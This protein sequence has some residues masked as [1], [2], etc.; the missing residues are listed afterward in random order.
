MISRVSLLSSLVLASKA[1]RA[2]SLGLSPAVTPTGFAICFTE[3]L[4]Y[5]YK[6]AYTA[7]QSSGTRNFSPTPNPDLLIVHPK[8]LPEHQL[9]EAVRLAES[10]VGEQEVF[11]IHQAAETLFSTSL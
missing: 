10:Y 4:R 8:S 7:Y 2:A 11:E 3:A 1:A 5:Q 6:G 9:E